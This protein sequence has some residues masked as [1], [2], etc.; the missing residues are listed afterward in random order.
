MGLLK[1]SVLMRAGDGSI[2]KHAHWQDC[3][4]TA[5]KVSTTLRDSTILIMLEQNKIKGRFK[6][7]VYFLLILK[8]NW[9]SWCLRFESSIMQCLNQQ[10]TMANITVL[11][12]LGEGLMVY[13]SVLTTKSISWFVTTSMIE[14]PFLHYSLSRWFWK[15]GA[16]VNIYHFDNL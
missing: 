3:V 16:H 1:R 15:Y 12:K 6:G 11:W 13:I 9:I 8:F 14:T 4:V 10:C 7:L 2:Y 5:S